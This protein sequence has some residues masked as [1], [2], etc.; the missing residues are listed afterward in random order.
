MRTREKNALPV[1]ESTIIGPFLSLWPPHGLRIVIGLPELR[2]VAALSC[3]LDGPGSPLATVEPGRAVDAFNVFVFETAGLVPGE[4]YSYRFESEGG[5]LN[6]D[7][8]LGPDDCTFVAPASF[9]D[10]DSFV[11]MSCNGPFVKQADPGDGPWDMWI[12]LLATLKQD[13]SIKLLVLAGDQLYNDC[14]EEEHLEGANFKSAARDITTSLIENYRRHWGSIHYRRVLARVPSVAMWDDHDIT[15]GWGGRPESFEDL[16]FNAAWHGYFKLA[17]EAFTKYQAVRNPEPLPGV[18]DRGFTTFIDLGPNRL[19]LLDLR[20]EKNIKN[21]H[22]R[23]L[24]SAEHESAFLESLRACPDTIRR[25]F[26]VSPVVAFRTNFAGD[27]R[28]EWYSTLFF[29]LAKWAERQEVLGRCALY[30][31][32]GLIVGPMLL[33][34]TVHG[35]AQYI[36]WLMLLLSGI[37]GLAGWFLAFQLWKV[38]ELPHLTDDLQDGL[39]AE[40]NRPTLVKLLRGI[41]DWKAQRSGAVALLSGEIH[42]A[43]V[44]EVIDSRDGVVS[45]MPQIVSSPIAYAPMPKPAEGFTTTTS[46]MVLAD[47]GNCR[48]FAR[49]VFYTSRRNFAQI[50]PARFDEPGRAAVLFHMERHELPLAIR[51]PFVEIFAP[52]PG[53]RPGA[54]GRKGRS[55]R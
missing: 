26:V 40:G 13:A 53:G 27:A 12:H 46:E 41:F 20:S 22:G 18:A 52:P 9:G 34:W 17:R 15:D 19:Y 37:V 24:W 21:G 44:S 38:P 42:L 25:L 16:Q 55:A 3:V 28:L 32:L 45:V 1:P 35:L 4:R 50:F 39:S 2:T 48:L 6:L 49:N 8:G 5:P 30:V 47:D 33:G 14:V 7:G 54:G 31:A 11:L 51:L 36:L 43:G 23:K 29:R 10:D